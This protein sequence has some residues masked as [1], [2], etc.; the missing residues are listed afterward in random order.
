MASFGVGEETTNGADGLL[1]YGKDD[2]RLQADFERLVAS[3]P[4]YGA[5]ANY[6]AAQEGYLEGHE[7]LGWMTEPPSTWRCSKTSAA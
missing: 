2:S 3:D 7:G 6:L 1:V 4:I 5:T